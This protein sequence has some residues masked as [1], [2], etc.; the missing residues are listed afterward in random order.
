MLIDSEC[1]ILVCGGR[2]FNDKDAVYRALDKLAEVNR[3]ILILHGACC[4]KDRPTELT[5]ADKFAQMW[6]QERQFPYIGVPARWHEF[7]DRAGPVRNLVMAERY[8]PTNVV[9]F[10]GGDGTD[11]MLQIAHE[12]GIQVWRPMQEAPRPARRRLPA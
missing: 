3:Y 11:G 7:G 4:R 9:A 1:R 6:A 2:D 10:P 5:G 12:R 8:L